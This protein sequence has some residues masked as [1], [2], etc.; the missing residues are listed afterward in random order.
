MRCHPLIDSRIVAQVF[1]MRREVQHPA[2]LSDEP[3]IPDAQAYGSVLRDRGGDWRMGYL[4]DPVYSGYYA[5]SVDGLNWQRPM[6]NLVAAEAH[7]ELNGPNAFLC[8]NQ[9]DPNGKWLVEKKGPEGFCV[10]DAEQN[11]HPAAGARFTSLYLARM[12]TGQGMY[13]AH[14]DDG[15]HWRAEKDHPVISGWRDTSSALLYD[16]RLKKYVWYGRPEAYAASH[17]QANRVI[18]RKESEDLIHWTPDH[19]V[20]DT[21][22]VDADPYDLV[23]EAALRLGKDVAS[24]TEC[25]KVWADLTEGARAG[26]NQP[27]IRGRNRQWYGITPFP[28]GDIY[29]GIA[30][31]YDIPNGDMWT[32]LVHSYDGID[33]R[34]EAIRVPFI[35]R[36]RGVCTCTMSSPPVV[37]GDDIWIYDSVQDKNHHGVRNPLV[38]R[39]IRA[40]SLQRDRWVGYSAGSSTGEMLTQVFQKPESIHLNAMTARNGWLAV[41]VADAEGCAIEGF[42]R[43]ECEPICGDGFALTPR[44]RSGRNL[45]QC[46]QSVVRLRMYAK[47]ARVFAFYGTSG[48]GLRQAGPFTTMPPIPTTRI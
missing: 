39:G 21:D 22:D 34:R 41:E 18:A 15:I 26:D 20:L 38:K 28:Y 19:T 16:T 17:M 11:P 10:L 5:H 43:A 7:G 9:K 46:K 48:C 45:R 32:E 13:I 40:M 33:W 25:A 14:S 37:V 6:L 23:D 8:R 42:S 1:A 3:V 44:W 4:G 24:A 2:L 27:L 29:L 12:Q 35:P 30:W 36:V 47:H 31:M